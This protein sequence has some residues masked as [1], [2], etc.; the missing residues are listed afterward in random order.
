ME[1]EWKVLDLGFQ[2]FSQPHGSRLTLCTCLSL[3]C[4]HPYDL[5]FLEIPLTSV[6]KML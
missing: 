5:Q 4:H 3:V 2:M 6:S 1:V